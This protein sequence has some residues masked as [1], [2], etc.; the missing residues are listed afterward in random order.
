MSESF[1]NQPYYDDFD[2][3][4]NFHRILFKPGFAVQ[5]RE[6][7]QSQTILQ[8]QVTKFADNIFKQNSPV[9][10]GNVTTNLNC[11]YIKLQ[12]TYSNSAIDV[13]LFNGLL[14]TN[15]DSSVIARVLAVSAATGTGTAG[16]PPTLVVQ[17]KSG[18]QFN[19]NDVIF[20]VN[21]N[22]AAQAQSINAT[23]LSSVAS[24]SQGVFYVL[25]NFVQISPT[26]IILG[27]YNNVPN[28]RVGLTIT[29]SIIDYI[30]D[31]SLLD[32]ALGASNYQAP[33]ADRYS[34]SLTL[35][36]R[37]LTLGDDQNFVELLRVTNGQVAK[38]V[39]GSVYA[40]I[41]D[42]FAKRDYETNGDYVVNDFKLTPKTN[43][44]DMANSTYIM[45]VG[46]GLAYVHGYR[47]EN[48]S[49]VDIITNRART[50]ASQNNNPVFLDYGSYLY[51]D[52]VNGANGS[53]FDVT[54][55]QSVDLHCVALANVNLTSSSTY[56]STLVGTGYLRGL[57]YDHN[58]NDGAANTYVYKAYIHDI[59]NAAPSANVVAAGTN[60]VTLPSTYSIHDGAYVGVNISIT[61]GTDIYDFR[62]I[63]AYNGTTKVATVNQ[64]WTVTP[65]TSSIFT[66]NFDIKDTELMLYAN[67][68]SYPATVDAWANLNA[69]G[70]VNG[71]STGNVVLQ[72]PGH[73]E[74]LFQIGNAYVSN[75][76]GVS[77]TAEQDW[78]NISFTT[79]GGGVSAQLSYTGDYIG[80]IRHIG[81]INQQQSSDVIKQNYVIVVTN[82]G[83][84][85]S[86]NVGDVLPW[87]DSSKRTLTLDSTG[88]VATFNSSDL[89]PF[90]ARIIS[91]VFVEDGDNTGHVLKYKNL[92]QAN[93]T[94]IATSNTQVNTYTFVDN[95]ALTSTGQVYIQNYGLVTPGYK[96]SLYL[97]DV[98]Q[99]IKIV[100]TGSPTV[101]PN[102]TN[103]STFTDITTNY[104][105]NT[106][107][108][109]N[110]YDHAF[111][112]LKSG[113][114]QPKGNILVFLN[115][116]QHTGGDGFFSVQ[117][118]ITSSLP[119]QYQQIPQYTSSHG[120]LYSLRD[121]VD[122]RPARLNAQTT[123]AW[124][125]ANS[126][127]T[128][129]YGIL[130][131]VDLS[132]F[133]GN[134][135]YYLARRDDLVLTKDGSFK[136]IEGT[137][138][139]TPLYPSEPDGAL[140][141]AQITHNPYTG[142]VTT[143]AP[144]GFVPDLSVIKPQHKRY[145]MQDIAA[146]ETRINNV[147]Y[148][149][150]LNALEQNASSLQIPDAYGLN[151][152]KN[153]IM[154]DDFSSFATAD[155]ANPDFYVTINN[156]TRILTA[157][158]KV[159]NFPLKSTALLKNMGLI[160]STTS[161][162]LGY[163]INSDGYVYYYSLPYT[164]ANVAVQPFASRTV[165]V[166]PFSFPLTNGTLELSPNVD[167][168][169]DTTVAPSLLITD[170][171]MQVFQGSTSLNVL[172]AGDWQTIP[173]TQNGTVVTN[174]GQVEG[175]NINP[176]PF[177]YYG[178]QFTTTT[179]YINQQRTDVIGP[180]SSIGN[181]YGLNNGYITNIGILPYIRTQQIV[182]RSVGLLYNSQL[183]T[184]FDGKFA[185]QWVR[186]S[187]IIELTG[188]TGTFNQDDA[189][190]YYTGGVFYATG[191]ILGT[192]NYPNSTN[193]RLY[194]AADGTASSYT[195]NGVIQNAYFD[196][197]G[198]YKST[199]ANGNLA[200]TEHYAGRI[201]SATSSTKI[202]LSGLA[203]TSD[204]YYNGNTIYINAGTGIG[205]SATISTYY[206]ANQTAILASSITTAATDI[207]S[208]GAFNSDESGSFY[209]IFNL[210]ASTFSNGQK[211]FRIDNSINGNSGSATTYAEGTFYAEGLQTTQQGVNFGASPSGAAGVFQS[212]QIQQST[213]STS[214]YTPWDPVAQT[215]MFD[216]NN[217]PNGLFLNSIKVFFQS[218]PTTDN[219]SVTL[220]I[221]GTLNGYPTGTTLNHSIV[222]LTPNKVTV[223][224]NPQFLDSTT[225]TEFVFSAPVYI[226]P[227]T[228]YAFMVKSPSKE[229]V[230]WTA[231]GGDTALAS[232][233]KNNPTDATP[234]T[235]TKI[236][237]A[238]YVGALFESQN[239]QTWTADQNQ[240]MMF[241]IDG[242]IFNTD[243]TPIIQHVVPQKLP[244]RTLVDQ[245]LQYY[246]NA[247]NV[248]ST[249]DL[250]TNHNVLVD[251]F[252]IT[253]TDFIPTTT[254][255]DYSYSASL[256]SGDATPAVP[257][258]PGKFGTPTQDDLYLSDGL[259]ERVLLAN[260]DTSFS[261]YTTLSS[262][263][264]YVSPIISDAGTSAYVIEWGISN[265]ELSN[266]LITITSGGTGYS[267]N[268]S[269]NVSVSISSPT[270]SGGTQ[271]YAS[272]NVANGVIQSIYI[273]TPGSGY[274]TTPAISI[275]DANTTPG[276][277]ATATITGET[278][279]YGGPGIAKYVTKKVVLDV[280][281]DS[282]D[283]TVY[284]DAYRPVNTDINVYYKILNRAD[285]QSFESGSWQ[286][287]TK[288][289]N[290]SSIYSQSRTDIKEFSFAP[291]TNGT[292]QGF[293]NY[294]STNG[295]TYTTFSQF[296][297]KI[298]LTT[299]DKTY[300]PFATSLRAIALPS[301][302]NTTN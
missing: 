128:T 237:A 171:N 251:A 140:I 228:L 161:S 130:Y 262:T 15:A 102:A 141:L 301:N 256:A 238:P 60:T 295:Q 38:M 297:V 126:G 71:L 75:L 67:K 23:G 246:L 80:V 272:A 118:Y 219:S 277:G 17:Y 156:R 226:A 109:D 159:Q 37:P 32:P 22:L 121:V 34:I 36:T 26:T 202:V 290:S 122:F 3:T 6:L 203:S 147:E 253:T 274:I 294:T 83:T 45:T 195:T 289:N 105:F 100:D 146:L 103:I 283:L 288:I 98:K 227:S 73:Q 201:T 30:N 77:Y 44:N 205:Q 250:V 148:Y 111:I 21:S 137:P 196:T 285:T 101:T 97:S 104:S 106:G 56:S 247:N 252:N 178:Y 172:S 291:G 91:K 85:S 220:S 271:A 163:A 224:Q 152:F 166:N 135:S 282:G 239:S 168:W 206:G 233:V 24:I 79:S 242:C 120:K 74:L 84:N 179:T 280:G 157:T 43:L 165:S 2:P 155:T 180:Y 298:V 99:I 278:S 231:A 174:T 183:N 260:T 35:D 173:G 29:E 127:D 76:S 70:R 194:V 299:T 265:C 131:P 39:D 273:T 12:P 177:G 90:T 145:T 10:G 198:T 129:R 63:T 78:R 46:K 59:Q 235:I 18:V 41:D 42:Y 214:T 143:E 258:S 244:Q 255:I 189:I 49:S 33:G 20:D 259:G 187:N 8:D 191:R 208:I 182:V 1:N 248:S 266:N 223:S 7:T 54:T 241:V 151:R 110:Y 243:V 222:T 293:V 64:N 93:T 150:S 275:S 169:V 185:N 40:T 153:G 225:Y 261:L 114:P 134:Y 5:A 164:T 232:S 302:V 192:Y 212:T 240:G 249:T 270:G 167:T 236:S 216:V 115:Y 133:T 292:D 184:F 158:Q 28:V 268:Q 154:T 14:I 162:T 123:F 50:T 119:E 204:N 287:M 175:H 211:V 58:T 264:K 108:K 92:I 149:A 66:L 210:P 125:Y 181:T 170:P 229:Y 276:T 31:T 199:T 286:L 279:P 86:I 132:T 25:G 113:A 95:N 160:D 144:A 11:Y 94:A 263:D 72:N 51:V 269:G 176:S 61:S 124:R 254:Q 65:D 138:S 16:D 267:N 52:T 55:T 87:T 139:L 9:T 88:S 47:V 284:V 221:L 117:S 296:A 19:D 234:S 116:Y 245:S 200:S 107:Q 193:V 300:T 4:K 215:F 207:Y 136:M 81:T 48:T 218:K 112:T 188:V 217:Y 82:K 57:I 142:Y 230:L 96:Q 13:S 62:T 186:K 213:I 209:G 190:G 69:E 27:K 197:N 68:A 53:F 89:S 257:V 281:N